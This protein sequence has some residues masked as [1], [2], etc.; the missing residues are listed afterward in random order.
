MFKPKDLSS[1]KFNINEEY[2]SKEFAQKLARKIRSIID[3]YKL[4]KGNKLN[5]DEKDRL[6]VIYDKLKY[7]YS[8]KAKMPIK[9]WRRFGPFYHIILQ[10]PKDHGKCSFQF[11]KNTI[12][13]YKKA[14]K[15]MM[16]NLFGGPKVNRLGIYFRVHPQ[17]RDD[18]EPEFHFHVV[19]SKV[20]YDME[21]APFMDIFTNVPREDKP[22]YA[23]Y[24]LSNSL[25]LNK[26]D[27]REW[28]ELKWREVINEI[29]EMKVDRNHP[30][31]VY[32]TSRDRQTEKD[33][34]DIAE[35]VI[36][37]EL[38][39]FKDVNVFD[40]KS[41]GRVVIEY[42]GDDFGSIPFRMSFAPAIFARRY[43]LLPNK[44]LKGMRW[45]A[46]GFFHHKSIFM[47]AIDSILKLSVPDSTS[48]KGKCGFLD[49]HISDIQE[50]A[51]EFRQCFDSGD[52]AGLH[53]LVMEY[54]QHLNPSWA[55][56]QLD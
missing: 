30:N 17:C 5:G 31:L 11:R 43:L 38:H 24:L 42:E 49:L 13:E 32:V 40:D 19:L 34:K 10:L 6:Q 20:K 46:M 12:S 44:A 53:K 50:R 29:T 33:R 54:R 26:K 1:M 52:K 27:L 15:P 36:R 23:M 22:I 16:E 18:R 9:N 56:D 3:D 41:S 48:P 39:I 4:L 47:P 28:V 51:L 35:Y 21:D 55:E 45:C 7:G 2:V 8:G 14:I 37:P 25:M